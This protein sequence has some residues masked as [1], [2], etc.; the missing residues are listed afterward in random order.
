[1]GCFSWNNSD[2]FVDAVVTPSVLWYLKA[3][4]YTVNTELTKMMFTPLHI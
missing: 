1:M 3:N 2:V 4:G